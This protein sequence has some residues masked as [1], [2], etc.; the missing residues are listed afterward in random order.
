MRAAY[1][2]A[3]IAREQQ[4]SE[5]PERG[6]RDSPIRQFSDTQEYLRYQYTNTS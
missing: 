5:M 2:A 1:Q 3:K 4:L 6:A